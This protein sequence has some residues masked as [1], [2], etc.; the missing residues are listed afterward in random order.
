MLDVKAHAALAAA[1]GLCQAPNLSISLQERRTDTTR[2]MIRYMMHRTRFSLVTFVM[3]MGCNPSLQLDPMITNQESGSTTHFIGISPVD[4]TVVWISGTDGTFGRTLDGGQTWK[5]GTV[6][7]ADSLQFRDVHGVDSETAYLLSIGSGVQSRIYKT[8]DGGQHWALQFTNTEP[9]GFFD[10]IGFWDAQSGLAFSDSFEGRFYII[11][12]RDGGTTWER[13][14]AESLPA[15]R[16]G[17][18]SFAASGHCLTV[19]GDSAAWIGTGANEKG[20]AR[21]LR[22]TD[23]G[24]SWTYADTPIP[25]GPVSGITSVAVASEAQI[26]VLGGDVTDM[27]SRAVNIAMSRDGGDTW[28]AAGRSS[29]PG[30]VYGASYVPGAPLPTLVAVGP[31]G[32]GFAVNDGASWTTLSTE[33]YWSVA[34]ASNRVGWAIGPEGRITRISLYR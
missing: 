12:T 24:Q 30:P 8:E 17:E 10:C 23:R 22:T 25:G 21:V 27:E 5:I 26:T 1:Q 4:E 7:G 20:P 9:A 29:F 6:P 19:G 15:A 34:F 2:Y 16:S 13:I 18:G 33:N 31:E 11:T 32:L 28:V 3:L 14:P